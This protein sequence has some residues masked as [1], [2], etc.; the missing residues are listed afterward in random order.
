[1]IAQANRHFGRIDILV[2]NAGYS[3]WTL[4][5]DATVEDFEDMMQTNYFGTVYATKAVLPLMLAR[6]SGHIVNVSS[7]AGRLGTPHH[8]HYCATKF[9]MTGFSESLWYELRDTGVGVTVVN[10]GVIDTELFEH[11]SFATF[12]AENRARMIPVRRLTDAVIDAVRHDRPEITVPKYF[13]LGIVVRHL[14]PGL[15]R[16]IMTRFS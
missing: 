3:R 2:N 4:A 13:A 7:I 12:P 10:P 6:R 5:R 15:F 16:R 14:A 8:T 9:A 1:M 11:P